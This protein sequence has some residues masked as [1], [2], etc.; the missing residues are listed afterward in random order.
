MKRRLTSIAAVAGL[1]VAT[2][3]TSTAAAASASAS[4]SG[5]ERDYLV[6]ATG[7][8]LPKGLADKVAAA[9]GE[10][11]ES[12]PEIGV[13]TVRSGEAGFADSV[14]AV[15]GIRS[16]SSSP[17]M[18]RL[19]PATTVAA[20]TVADYGNPPTSGDDD[21]FFDLQW[22]HDAV[23]APE[24]WDEGRRGA[25][26]R[27]AVLDSGFDLDHPDLVPNID[28]ATSESFVAGE[29]LQY[30]LGDPFSHGTHTA[31]TVGAA[32]NAFGTIG[33][34]P[35]TT[36]VLVKV[37][38]DAGCGG[39]GPI[40]EGIVHAAGAGDAD[41]I[42][43]SLGAPMD[44][45]GYLEPGCDAGEEDDVY[46][47][48][49]DVAEIRIAYKRAVDYATAQGTTV[50]ASAGNEASDADH[51][52]DLIHL[53]AD[54]PGVLSISATAPRGWATDPTTAFLDYPASYTNYGRSA[55][56]FSAPGGDVAYP[57]NESCTV[58]G[59]ARPCWVF[60]LVF[61]TGNGGWYW[62]AGTSMAAPHASGVAA[63]VIG[64]NGGEMKP[65]KVAAELR[66]LADRLGGGKDPVYGMGAIDATNSVEDD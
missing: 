48:A 15:R 22:G 5:P 26:T 35:E 41:V 40:L 18:M 57:G 6:L 39:D 42:N 47:T 51:T 46:M 52:A 20:P 2:L 25:G 28:L 1:A 63:L 29:P 30:G 21:F 54:V 31:G 13:M 27:V 65:S 56:D 19:E 38:P 14:R 58:A 11:V 62:S 33:V 7:N 43:M 44:K 4:S 24:A 59:L 10:V 50:I 45:R 34:A 64:A 8:A 66:T 37:L 16:V 61:S 53:P 60:D 12:I 32:D 9:G 3:A 23:D 36:L 17:A 55:I 49:A